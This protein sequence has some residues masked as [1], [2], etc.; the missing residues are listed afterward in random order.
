MSAWTLTP[1]EVL[2]GQNALELGKLN[3]YEDAKS[4]RS[5]LES[6]VDSVARKVDKDLNGSRDAQRSL[7]RISRKR[8]S[9]VSTERLS[10]EAHVARLIDEARAFHVF[11]AVFPGLSP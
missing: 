10:V 1:I 5:L 4:S 3:L 11:G 6:V 9:L 2:N 7:S 8:D